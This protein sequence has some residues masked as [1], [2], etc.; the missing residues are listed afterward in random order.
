MK[1]NECIKPKRHRC[2]DVENKLV[3]TREEREGGRDE[4]GKG[5]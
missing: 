3:V 1:T 4:V 2:T 5:D